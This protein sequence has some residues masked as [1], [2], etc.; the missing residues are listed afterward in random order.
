MVNQYGA[1]QAL[2][3]REYSEL[4]NAYRATLA[5]VIVGAALLTGL[6][7]T[8]RNTRAAEDGRITDR[9]SKAVDLL[10]AEKDGK[11]QI[12]PRLGGLCAL[13]RIARDS[14]RDRPTIMEILCAYVRHNA[15][16]KYRTA[17]PDTGEAVGPEPDRCRPDAD[18][19]A[20]IRVLKRRPL[21][22]GADRRVRLDLNNTELY[23]AD[24][25][26]FPFHSA[27]LSYSF[28]SRASLRA[29]NL[30]GSDLS[31]A[32]A[33]RTD[34]RKAD[35][36]GANL[37]RARLHRAEFF[38]AKARG[39]NFAEANLSAAKLKGAQF[40]S[41]DGAR[42]NFRKAVLRDTDLR[43]VD[44]REVA[45]LTTLQL[46]QAITDETT[47]LPDLQPDDAVPEIAEEE[48][49]ESRLE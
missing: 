28:L 20:A 25:S 15:P 38:G 37:C 10:G 19:E 34:F 17:D 39:T 7:Y 49:Q 2:T 26:G 35:L 12:E 31:N 29:A 32:H 6:Y 41:L 22:R 45:G 40:G 44:L 42:T 30:A 8:A 14:N 4:V 16:R 23:E 33:D 13:E 36:S 5:Q 48:S 46:G 18:I 21:E 47:I 1:G 3:R 11:R 43:G 24:L 9:F 27:D